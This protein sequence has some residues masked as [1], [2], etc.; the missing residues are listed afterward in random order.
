MSFNGAVTLMTSSH[1]SRTVMQ[2]LI[3]SVCSSSLLVVTVSVFNDMD[4]YISLW[5]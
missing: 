2:A 3:S 4:V 5:H 1:Y